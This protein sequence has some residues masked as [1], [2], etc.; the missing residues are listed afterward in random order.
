MSVPR[1]LLP[2][3]ATPGTMPAGDTWAYEVKWD[4]VRALAFVTADAVR[5]AGR[6]GRDITA[7]YPELAG[8]AAALGGRDA[9][10][11][12][13]IVACDD[14]GLPSFER[15]QERMHV[16][17]PA[18]VTQ[19]RARTPVVYMVFDLLALDGASCTAL[20]YRDRRARLAELGLDGPHWQAPPFA[21]GDPG[22]I[23]AFTR[24]RDIEGVVAKRLDSRYE[25]GRRSAMWLKVKHT[26]R[27]EFVV[28]GWTPGVKGRTGDIGA[29]VLGVYEAGDD[30]V[31][32]L[33]CCGKV[34]S[35]LSEAARAQLRERLAPLARAS[36]PFELGTVPRHTHF[37]EPD[38]VVEVEFAQWTTAQVVRAAV[39]CGLRDDKAGVAVVRE[40]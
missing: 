20:P 14:A 21:A 15:L 31:A 29:L 40:T 17:D 26:K 39:Y 24:E 10:L 30:G 37:V 22:P 1:D 12:G 2:K 8:L 9:V 16:D 18:L 5:L 3:L 33:R 38:L 13:E 19:L 36:S 11:D 27:Q 23:V 6:N 4:G 7:R 34:G 35:G 28:G 32:Q 25:P